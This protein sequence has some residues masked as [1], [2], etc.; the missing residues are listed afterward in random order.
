MSDRLREIE[1]F[2]R[3]AGTGSFS[4]AARELGLSQPSASRLVSR[5]EQRLGVRL[6]LRTTRRVRATEAGRTYLESARRAL[7]ELEEARAGASE[8]SGLRGVLRVALSTGF[9][10][11]EIVPRRRISPR[12]ADKRHG[13]RKAASA[14][15]GRA[16]PP[17]PLAPCGVSR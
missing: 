2:V 7:A 4:R 1:V 10:C 12:R 14:A 15:P 3:A 11:R 17:C 8:D 9:G 16:V 6:L 5:L 13:L